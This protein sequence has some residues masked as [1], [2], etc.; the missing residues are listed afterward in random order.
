[1]TAANT[2][3]QAPQS[4]GIVIVGGGV[5]GTSVAYHLALLGRTDVVLVDQ[6]P[7]W[8]TGGS[9]S[10]APGLVF[11]HNPSRTMTRFAQETVALFGELGCFHGVGGIEV[12]AT[13]ARWEE[14]HRRLGRAMSY[15][16]PAE[17]L[18]PEQVRE[19]VPL[20]DPER[21]LGGFHTPTDGIA[22]AL[23]AAEAMATATAA[24]MRS[25]TARS[26]ASR[27][28]AARPGRRD[29]ARHDPHRHRRPRRRHLGAEGRAARRAWSCRS[30]RSSTSTRSPR[31]CR[32]WRAR[33]ARWSTRSCATRT[34][35]STSARSPTPTGS[36]TTTTSRG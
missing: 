27:S 24:C 28:S 32:S 35:T 8:E 3:L 33:R 21:I 12:A 25:A 29:D 31:R 4:A 5:A 9:T 26:R 17:L 13:E 7:L 18:T 16:L 15:G 1:M 14:L 23:H 6:G 11:Q 34:P 30:S 36:A 20:I 10:H 22:K 2:P 19:L